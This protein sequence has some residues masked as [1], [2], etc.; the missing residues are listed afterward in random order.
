LQVALAR[1]AVRWTRLRDGAPEAYLRRTMINELTSW[2]RRRR[3][4]EHPAAQLPD[5]ADAG[6]LA[7]VVVR[8]VAVGRALVQLTPAQRAVLVLRFYEDLSEAETAAIL[9]CAIGT[10][11]SRSHAALARLRQVAPELIEF[12]ERPREVLT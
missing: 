3:Y 9:G 5:G 10:V 6:D 7:S 1:V 8:R 11:K 12:I 4:H 2:R